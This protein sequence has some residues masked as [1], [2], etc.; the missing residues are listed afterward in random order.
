MPKTQADELLEGAIDFHAHIYPQLTLEESGRVLD[1]EWAEVARQHGMRGFVMKSHLWPT[2]AQAR[3]LSEVYPGVTAMGSIVLNTNVG[4]LSPFAAESAAR[5]GAKVIWMPTY[6]S[7]NDIK[8]NAF[9]RRVA[10]TYKNRPPHPPAEGGL[11]VLGR[12]GKVLPE[13]VAILEIARDA[14]IVV[15]TGHLSAEEGLALARCAKEVGLKKFVYTHPIIH[16]VHASDAQMREVADM[17]YIVEFTWISAFPM[18]QGLDPKKIAAAAKMLGP[19][20]CIMTTDAQGDVNPTPP[21]MLR[22][23]IA[24]M[25]LLGL[26]PDDVRWM[27]QRNPARLANLEG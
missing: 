18:W 3:V 6:T 5:L 24:S 26:S 11:T 9:S 27:V 17:G 1:H 21:E 8:V 25:L 14:D 20:R 12:D 4:G 23:F 10:A 2:V 7:A 16:I 15:A 13:A 19:E 22:M